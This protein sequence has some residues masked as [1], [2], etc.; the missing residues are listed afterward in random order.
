MQAQTI[1][2]GDHLDERHVYPRFMRD[3]QDIRFHNLMFLLQE[4]AADLGAERGAAAMLAT[5]SGV[6]ASL[7]SMLSRRVLHSDTG[8]RRHIGDETATKLEV[9]MSKQRGWMD[10]DRLQARNF[11]EAALLDKM[12]C[13]TPG[14]LDAL[15]KLLDQMQPPPSQPAPG[16]EGK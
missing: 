8:K 3:I 5:R 11:K 1:T 9:G 6:K 13:L 10:V 2:S 15:E 4:C 12:R 7:L 16:E 14:Q